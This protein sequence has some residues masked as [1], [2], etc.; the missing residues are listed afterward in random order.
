[1]FQIHMPMAP[2][3]RGSRPRLSAG[4]LA[5]MVRQALR[6]VQQSFGGST[7][8]ADSNSSLARS[9]PALSVESV[10]QVYLA[11]RRGNLELRHSRCFFF[12]FS[13]HAGNEVLT[14][15]QT[16]SRTHATHK[17]TVSA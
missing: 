8:A 4:E 15:S 13:L 5:Q 14:P 10:S 12:F 2:V 7:A 1:M 9:P 17:D 16:N 6:A 3:T 11:G